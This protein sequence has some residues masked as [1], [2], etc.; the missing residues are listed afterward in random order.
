MQ[1][2]FLF[3]LIGLIVGMTI[4]FFAANLINKRDR[5]TPTNISTIEPSDSTGD[6]IQGGIQ[7]DVAETLQQAE[8]EPQNFAVQMKTG[9]MYARIGRFDKAIE[10]YKRGVALRP[11]DLQANV[12]I[13]NAFFDSGKFEDAES[14]YSSALLIDPQNINAR[15]DL[16]TTF[17]ERQKPDYERAIKEFRS[18]LEID[19][20]HAPTLYYLGIAY[21]RKGD[22][23]NANKALAE[24][25]K[26]DPASELIGK[27]RQNM[28]KQ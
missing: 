14:F 2:H 11:T 13:A 16:G 12:V 7:S 19:P 15:T 5:A 4:G 24:L 10:F 1:K 18:A 6:Q 17:V 9:D 21:F 23:E 22:L 20:K 8:A 27:L 3:G 28:A 25:E 26:A